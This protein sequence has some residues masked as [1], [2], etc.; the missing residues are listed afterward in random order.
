MQIVGLNTEL[1]VAIATLLSPYHSIQNQSM[2]RTQHGTAINYYGDACLC[3]WHPC[4]KDTISFRL[5]VS[6]HCCFM[7]PH[8]SPQVKVMVTVV[9]YRSRD[10]LFRR[11]PMLIYRLIFYSAHP[12]HSDRCEAIEQHSRKM[13]QGQRARQKY[14]KEEKEKQRGRKLR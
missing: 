7:T 6:Q 13:R 14:D 5:I 2:L 3:A 1:E 12:P 10:D 8:E 11:P 9:S 4:G